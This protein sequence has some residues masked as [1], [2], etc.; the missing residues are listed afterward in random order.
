MQHCVYFK[1]SS[2]GRAPSRMCVNSS[3][4]TKQE[5]AKAGGEGRRSR[6][7]MVRPS[8]RPEGSRK[9]LSLAF[10]QG[11]RGRGSKPWEGGA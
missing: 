2:G 10:L 7:K 5:Q 3:P 1:Y 8:R 11:N 4:S 6:T 9:T